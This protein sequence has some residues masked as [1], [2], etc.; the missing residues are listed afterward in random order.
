[1]NSLEFLDVPFETAAGSQVRSFLVRY[2]VLQ[3]PPLVA[4]Q[5]R[6]Q[7]GRRAGHG[8]RILVLAAPGGSLSAAA[9]QPLPRRASYAF[10]CWNSSPM[11]SLDFEFFQGVTS[12][13]GVLGSAKHCQEFRI[14]VG[15]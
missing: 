9:A 1:M 2:E 13:E 12:G 5:R 7:V 10:L 3:G 4:R 8:Q 14:L 15:S 11:Q 6:C